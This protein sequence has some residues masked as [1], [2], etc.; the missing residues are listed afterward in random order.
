MEYK[1]LNYKKLTVN[2]IRRN[3]WDK[4]KNK[5]KPI[6][7]YSP[8]TYGDIFIL[9]EKNPSFPFIAFSIFIPDGNL[10][11]ENAKTGE[12]EIIK[13]WLSTSIGGPYK[14]QDIKSRGLN[15]F[16]FLGGHSNNGEFILLQICSSPLNVISE[17]CLDEVHCWIKTNKSKIRD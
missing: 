9:S 5:G 11:H 17:D 7:Y 1:V 4:E 3:Y 15:D 8:Q 14:K 16:Y 13:G 12:K 2:D 10:H 6:K